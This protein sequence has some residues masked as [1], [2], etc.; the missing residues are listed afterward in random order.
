MRTE[1]EEVDG[2]VQEQY[3]SR[4]REVLQEMRE[5]NDAAIEQA[6]E[7]TEAMYAAKV[8]TKVINVEMFLC[9]KMF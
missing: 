9:Q 1:I 5:E 6:R 4:L 8:G 7:D 2:R 3:E